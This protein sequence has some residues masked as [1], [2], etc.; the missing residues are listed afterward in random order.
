MLNEVKHLY[1]KA[2]RYFAL[3]I[4][5]MD[6]LWNSYFYLFNTLLKFTSFDATLVL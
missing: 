2:M 1:A 6:Q 4:T 5:A 3:L